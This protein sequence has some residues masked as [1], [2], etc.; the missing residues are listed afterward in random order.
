M[1]ESNYVGFWARTG[2]SIIDT[3]LLLMITWPLLWMIYGEAYFD[4]EET[5]FIAGPAD[6]L[7]TWILPLIFTLVF[8]MRKQGTPGKLVMSA[9][10]VD[11]KTG[12]SLSLR[13]SAIRYLGYFVSMLPLCLGFFWVAFDKKKQSWHDKIAG[14]VVVRK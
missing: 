11:E 3:I 10:V 5:S 7:I 8:W 9:H 14:T 6:L 2:A 13:Q 4:F 12:G 1:S